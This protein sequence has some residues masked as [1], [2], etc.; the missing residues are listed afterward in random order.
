M[1]VLNQLLTTQALLVSLLLTPVAKAP[2]EPPAIGNEPTQGSSG[3]A[4]APS[5][6]TPAVQKLKSR[7]APLRAAG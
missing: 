3:S 6:G 5:P 4:T 1:P 2:P 7:L